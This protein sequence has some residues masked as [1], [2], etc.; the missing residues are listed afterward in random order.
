ML[1]DLIVP[2]SGEA[3][4]HLPDGSYDVYDFRY[5]GLS[6]HNRWNV[7]GEPTLYLA[8]SIDVAAAEWSRH[9][10]FDRPQQLAAKTKRRKIYR[11]DVTLSRTLNLSQ[12]QLWQELSLQNA[13]HCF[14]AQNVA[15]ATAQFIRQTTEVE[16][17]FVPSIAF[18]DRLEK[19]VLV[20]FLEKLS[21]HDLQQ[22]LPAV[23]EYGFLTLED[24]NN[25]V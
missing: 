4:R 9:F 3:F 12:P 5:A 14:L 18:L 21:S 7:Q 16:A 8:G 22:F 15:R 24:E 25:E 1:S 17:I 6:A 23:K 20:I 2:W 19:W 11:F 13:P 10:Q